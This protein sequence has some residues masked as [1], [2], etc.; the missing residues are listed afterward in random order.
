MVG[1]GNMGCI[2]VNAPITIY[3][4]GTFDQTYQWKTGDP[5]EAVDLSEYTAKM[6]ARAKMTDIEPLIS[7][8]TGTS[9]WDE[10]GDSGIYL[11]AGDE[12]K[13][14]IYINDED[15][16]NLC[17]QHKDILGVYDLFLYSPGGEALLK[18]YGVCTFVA[19][20][21]RT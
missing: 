1:G 5:A 8:E 3:E 12:G 17:A 20:S 9:P 11:D 4:G 18:Q 21:T 6:M 15:T 2:A 13:Y 19:A 14:Q 7:I 16:A 10:D